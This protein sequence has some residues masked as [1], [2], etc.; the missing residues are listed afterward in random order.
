LSNSD[1]AVIQLAESI[2]HYHHEN[3][4]GSGY[5]AG[6]KGEGIPIAAR[7]VSLVD[8]YDAL[9]SNRV[10]RAGLEEDVVLDFLK[11]QRGIKFDPE[12]CDL[13]FKHKEEMSIS[14]VGLED[15]MPESKE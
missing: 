4:D 11:S 10:Y 12:L 13:F 15:P 6:L 9:R 5:P 3:W 7:I 2:A 14:C 1:N 8:V